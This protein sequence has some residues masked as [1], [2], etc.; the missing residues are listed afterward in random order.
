MSN[1]SES[2]LT[3]CSAIFSSFLDISF[4]LLRSASVFFLLVS[5]VHKNLL[6]AHSAKDQ[7]QALKEIINDVNDVSFVLGTSCG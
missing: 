3:P 2:F 4:R 7:E 6:K 1:E 5:F